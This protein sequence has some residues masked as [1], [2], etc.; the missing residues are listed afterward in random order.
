M[1]DTLQTRIEAAWEG[2]DSLDTGADSP[3]RAD[4]LEALN[5]LDSGAARVA[6]P[7]GQGGWQ[8]NQWLKKAVLL[9]FR[10]NPMDLISGA[11]GGA[12]WWDKVPSKF[13]GWSADEFKAAGFRAVPGAVA[14]RGA[15][16]AKDAV[17]MPSF[18]NIGAHVGEGTMVDTWATVGSCA[19]IGRNVHI[20]GGVGIGGVLEPL[21][22]GP[23]IIEDNC[24]IGARSEVAEG[25]IVGEGAVLSMGVY[26]GASTRIVDRATGEVH[27]GKVPPYA[28]VVPGAMPGKPLP[29][30]TPGPSLYCAVIVKTVDAQTRS[31]TGINELLRS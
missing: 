21:Q 5:L 28:V 17:L 2:R 11:P 24:F 30:G 20:S 3:V 13:D 29:D 31:K 23:V 27:Y 7:D 26:L 12:S 15:F 6:E 10:L 4:V 14:R 25:V 19:Q 9:S 8:V 22:A 1:T 18:V 16:I